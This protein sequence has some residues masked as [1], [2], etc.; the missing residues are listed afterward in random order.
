MDALEKPPEDLQ[1]QSAHAGFHSGEGNEQWHTA[2]HRS[3][4]RKLISQLKGFPA[5][6]APGDNSG[7]C[8]TETKQS[9]WDC[10]VAS[11]ALL[12]HLA[13]LVGAVI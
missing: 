9:S 13:L 2:I 8:S 12:D 1:V 11:T 10:P 3:S 5:K 7:M 6:P 4:T